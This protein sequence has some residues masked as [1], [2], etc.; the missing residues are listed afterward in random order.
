VGYF[1]IGLHALAALFHHYVSRDNTLT[2]M[3]PGR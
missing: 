3:L 1:L 2:R